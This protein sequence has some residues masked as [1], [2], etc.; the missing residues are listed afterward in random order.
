[1]A[2]GSKREAG[3]GSKFLRGPKLWSCMAVKDVKNLNRYC[4]P[5]MSPC[6]GVPNAAITVNS[7]ENANFSK[8]QSKKKFLKS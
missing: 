1:M 7:L 2:I 5:K 4:N 8:I 3:E 6:E